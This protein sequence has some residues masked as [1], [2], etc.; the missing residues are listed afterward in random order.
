MAG[1]CFAE[2]G[3]QVPSWANSDSWLVDDDDDEDEGGRRRA[4]QAAPAS[5][6][7]EIAVA[8]SGPSG[9]GKTAAVVAIAQ[10]G[11]SP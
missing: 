7:A 10:V 8:L 6:G 1:A 5:R 3:S 4:Q 11:W 9:C 2:E